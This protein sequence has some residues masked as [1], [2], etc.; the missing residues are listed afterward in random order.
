MA[1]ELGVLDDPMPSHL[2]GLP[3]FEEK[4]CKNWHFFAASKS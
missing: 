2:N 4:G 3:K 1:F